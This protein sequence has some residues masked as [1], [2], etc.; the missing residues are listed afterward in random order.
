MRR[1]DALRIRA[2]RTRRRMLCLRRPQQRLL[3]R[4]GHP[5]LRA[6]RLPHG[7]VGERVEQEAA[8]ASG[9]CEE[10]VWR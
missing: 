2:R 3:Q 1:E 10:V 7:L 5:V 8:A 4:Q 9:E 6:E